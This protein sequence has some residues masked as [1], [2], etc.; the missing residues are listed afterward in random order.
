METAH[1]FAALHTEEFYLS[2]VITDYQ[3]WKSG[4][5]WKTPPE[6]R[7]NTA[8]LLPLTRV[9]RYRLSG[10]GVTAAKPGELLILPL[11]SVYSCSFSE[12][13]KA[14]PPVVYK[15]IERSSLF[16]GFRIFGK[17]FREFTFGKVPFLPGIV[18]T[19]K[20]QSEFENLCRMKSRPDYSYGFLCSASHGF[21]CSLS[22]TYAEKGRTTCE[23]SGIGRILSE[24][25][26]TKPDAGPEKLAA[27]CGISPSSLRRACKKEFGMTPTETIRKRRLEK[28]KALLEEGGL[29]V[30]DVA[31]LC[32]FEDE[33]YF[34]RL[35][36]RETGIPPSVYA[37][38][39]REKYR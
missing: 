14:L 9:F 21:L 8:I 18:V 33:F 13:D 28:A 26:V 37:A 20:M 3:I 17:G 15:N 1:D 10:G 25:D 12:P 30:K 29:R 34:S 5:S 7:I 6:G 35:F 36:T 23:K 38:G 32:G 27:A 2:D 11:G 22:K 39:M 16:L 24:F 4:Q 19:K 31:A